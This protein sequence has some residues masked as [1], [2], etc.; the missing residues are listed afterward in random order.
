MPPHILGLFGSWV[1]TVLLLT[2]RIRLANNAGECLLS[3]PL[4]DA[5]PLKP[6]I[7]ECNGWLR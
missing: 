7:A 4:A 3:S 1:I 5:A 6:L 2:I